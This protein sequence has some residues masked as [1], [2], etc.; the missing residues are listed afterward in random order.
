MAWQ[1]LDNQ[2]GVEHDTDPEMSWT[3]E[4]IAKIRPLVGAARVALTANAFKT[5][6]VSIEKV[7]DTDD[8]RPPDEQLFLSRFSHAYC[9]CLPCAG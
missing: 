8:L 3:C 5:I 6:A 4:A 9:V 1:V 2:D 7:C